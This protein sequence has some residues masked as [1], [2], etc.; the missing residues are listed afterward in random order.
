MHEPNPNHTPPLHLPC[1]RE[2]SGTPSLQKHTWSC[3]ALGA[4][5]PSCRCV[6]SAGWDVGVRRHPG[7]APAWRRRR[8]TLS[9]SL[10]SQ[11]THRCPSLP[12][13]LLQAIQFSRAGTL[14]LPLLDLTPPWGSPIRPAVAAAVSAALDGFSA[15]REQPVRLVGPD[16]CWVAVLYGRV[17]CCH[18]DR[19]AGVLRLYRMFRCGG[20]WGGGWVCRSLRQDS[21]GLCELSGSSGQHA[22]SHP[23]KEAEA[24]WVGTPLDLTRQVRRARR[25]LPP[26]ALRLCHPACRDATSL[27]HQYEVYAQQLELSVVDNVLLVRR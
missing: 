4:A 2:C 13:T 20:R 22:G 17:F 18:H 10:P 1:C 25:F 16:T 21:I 12:L 3:W 15:A 9:L 23:G 5:V 14:K 19:R 8:L 6:L 27:A 11:P 24:S 7:Q 26:T